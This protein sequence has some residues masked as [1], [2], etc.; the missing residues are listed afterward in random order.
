[1]KKNKGGLPSLK[2]KLWRIFSE[3]IRRRDADEN[4]IA[5]CISCGTRKPWREMDAGHYIPKSLG[6]S[7]YF[8]ET[9]VHSQCRG[10]NS[11]RHG[12]LS[13]YALALKRRYG[14]KILEDLDAMRRYPRKFTAA[15][16]EELIHDYE[17][18]LSR[19]KAAA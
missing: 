3:Y 17:E 4:G 6:L 14:E 7:I 9:N 8:L 5:S 2:R 1:M 15:Q 11:F 18:K 10:C 16:Y 13:S 19:I 12:N